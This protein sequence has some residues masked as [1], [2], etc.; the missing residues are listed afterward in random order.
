VEVERWRAIVAE[1]WAEVETE[2]L[3]EKRQEKPDWGVSVSG[4]ICLRLL[5]EKTLR[6]RFSR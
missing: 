1:H 2:I 5:V 4:R 6:E 3:T